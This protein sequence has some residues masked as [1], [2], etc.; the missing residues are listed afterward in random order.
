VPPHVP[1]LVKPLST[2]PRNPTARKVDE[3]I[4]IAVAHVVPAL[5]IRIELALGIN[6][7]MVAHERVFKH[8]VF[9]G[10][11][12]GACVVLAHEHGVIRH[13]LKGPAGECG[14]AE[15]GAA[16]V[17]GLV[18]LSDEDVDFLNAVLGGG[19]DVGRVLLE[20]A[21]EDRG[22]AHEAALKGG[23]RQDLG[24]EVVVGRHEDDVGVDE[25]D[26][27]GVGVQVEGLGDGGDLGPCL[28]GGL[29]LVCMTWA[30]EGEGEGDVPCAHCQRRSGSCSATGWCSHAPRSTSRG[31]RA[32]VPVRS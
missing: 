7:N 10:V 20:L 16:R 24:N 15:E 9:E 3:Q 31:R 29:V 21:V 17:D 1:E 14:A 28:V 25:P 11:L 30:G 23:G 8:E 4:A 2:L 12:F 27:F 13:H 18:V 26:P 6:A 22:G 19:A 32:R 5:R